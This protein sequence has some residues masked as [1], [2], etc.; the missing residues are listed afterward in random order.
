ML[1]RFFAL[2]IIVVLALSACG[3]AQ[4]APS[5]GASP[6]VAPA[7]PTVAPAAPTVAPAAPT[8]APTTPPMA[9]APT[10]NVLAAQSFLADIAQNVAGDR[11]KV[12]AL[13]PLGVDPHIFEPTPADVR[14]VADS[15]VL[16][17]NGAGF[18][19]FLAGL[20][21]NA[22]GERLVIEASKGLS[23]RTARE[24]E[25]AV[26]SPEELTDA[27]C[28]E[29]ADLFLAAEEITAGAERAS[30]VEV[31]AH[32]EKEADHGHDHEHTHDHGGMFW[33]VMLN[34]QADG[35]Y[36]GFLKW[37]AEGG[38]I[39][40]ATGDGALVVT[41]IDTGAAL[42][43][44]ETLTLNCSGLT[45]AMIM[46]VEKG[47]YLLELTGFRAPQA[48][49]MIGT[50]GGHH[51]HDEGDPHFWLDPMNVVTYVANIRDGLIS[52]DPAGAEV[53]RANAERYIAQLNELDRFIASE[54][55]AIPEANRKLVTNHESFGYFAD[56]YGFRIIGTIVPGVTTGASPSAQQL[57]RLTERVRDAGVKVI[58]LET[59]ANPQLAE[60]LARET[61]ITIVSDLYTHSLS[62]AD[63]PAPTYIDMM[64]YNVKRI[65]EA[66][67]Q[68]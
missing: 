29:A 27:L 44:E 9:M 16:I 45:Q 41:G 2:M 24:G 47:E 64:R 63:G 20:L 26:M 59:G 34:R 52:V 5:G 30:A 8:V 18:E 23:S 66:L 61:G 55:A 10:L 54:V 67:K 51:H 46:D 53:Y 3:G 12:E 43:A 6:T 13:I 68:G 50:P 21:E 35:T 65:V 15:D 19:E 38:E 56:R 25:V 62:E 32:A 36:A 1:T 37:D 42:D 22:G 11:L 39:A 33:Q 28:V 17:V 58:F 60:Q 48:T 31:G 14:K 57:A 4:P 7:A 49:L 40:I